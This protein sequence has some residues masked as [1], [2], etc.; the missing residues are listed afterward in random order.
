MHE[1]PD[2]GAVADRAE[3]VLAPALGLVVDLA[4]VVQS[5]HVAA[6]RGSGGQQRPARDHFR[7]RDFLVRQEAAEPDLL[8]PVIGE[9]ADTDTLALV[10]ALQQQGAIAGQSRVAEITDLP[11]H[12]REPSPG[13]MRVVTNH[14]EAGC[15]NTAMKSDSP[16]DLRIPILL[17]MVV[18]DSNISG[19]SRSSA[20]T[21]NST[22]FV[23][24]TICAQVS[25]A[26]ERKLHAIAPPKVRLGLGRRYIDNG[27][28]I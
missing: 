9:P 22:L 13:C 27:S 3:R 4:G 28:R 23:Q 6:D 7:H 26:G 8:G 15:S 11:D 19:K 1:Q 16:G 14:T 17:S 18:F 24:R 10:H 20:P 21:P 5:Q 2:V 25:L 12:H